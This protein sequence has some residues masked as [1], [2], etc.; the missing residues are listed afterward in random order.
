MNTGII[1]F[2]VVF[3]A[4]LAAA[5]PAAADDSW[6]DEGRAQSALE[7]IFDKANHPAKI[8]SLELHPLE[9]EVELQDPAQT[10]HIDAWTDTIVLGTFQRLV[11]GSESVSGPRPVD[12]TLPNPNL[13]ANLF[14]FKP[15]DAATVPKLVADAVKRAQ[16][17]DA[18]T[19]A[20]MELR[21]QLHLVP[22][23]SSGPPEWSIEVTSGRERAEIYADLAG[24]ITHANL[25]GTRRA[26]ALNYL[27]GGK[28]LDDV[29]AT[30]A[31][32]FPKEPTIKSVIVYNHYLTLEALNPEHPDRY[33]R[34]TA[35][36]NGVYRDLLLDSVVNIAIPNQE[37]P[38]R[39]AITDIDWS[40]LPKL[41]QAARDRMQ[42]PGGKVGL[43]KLTKPAGVNG[44]VIEWEINIQD[45][46][47][48]AVE[49]YVTFDGKGNILRT[50]YPPGR[51]PKLDF[52][53]AASYAPAFDGMTSGLGQ[54]AQ[55]VE[56]VFWPDKVMITTKDPQK[57]DDLVVFE[58]HGESLS[59]SIMLPLNWPTFG[60]DWF[61]DLSQAQPIAARWSLL[62]Q[63]TLARLGL[64]GGKIER[65]TISKQ[66]L[67]MPRNDR[68]LIEIR[69]EEGRRDGRVVYDLNGK[70]VDIVTP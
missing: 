26:Q 31:D 47:D 22:E 68:V 28:E 21:R 32:V 48:S 67:F 11:F 43:V 38:G 2:G 37:P 57:P 8:L 52:L 51:G 65:I 24:H 39:F 60:P 35:G 10:K 7:K 12:P 13:D 59:R 30:I 17:E 3:A 54:H 16:L 15:A 53:D 18:A 1:G 70:I 33:S 64:T 62:Q 49:G 36:L 50:H 58:Y 46:G 41:E 23:P 14:E 66:K 45:A 61:F 29:V 56:L 5:L 44:P 42:L 9:L 4:M 34:F 55:M 19:I 27:N 6:F 20:R 25:D 63:D 40:L 69:A